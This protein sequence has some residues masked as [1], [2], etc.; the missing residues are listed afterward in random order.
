MCH[1]AN[2]LNQNVISLL[3]MCFDFC[4]VQNY[5]FCLLNY[6]NIIGNWFPSGSC[7]L[8]LKINVR[9]GSMVFLVTLWFYRV[10]GSYLRSRKVKVM[11]R[12]YY[13]CESIRGPTPPYSSKCILMFIESVHPPVFSCYRRRWKNPGRTFCFF[14]EGF[15][16]TI[17]ETIQRIN[18]C[19]RNVH[20]NYQVSKVSRPLVVRNLDGNWVYGLL[21][22][23]ICYCFWH[24][25]K[26]FV[27]PKQRNCWIYTN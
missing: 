8:F 9:F 16:G 20:S 21:T 13:T 6:P 4:F 14:R 26:I 19:I 17:V 7:S 12:Q 10:E 18:D 15:Q 11:N 22:E 3:R 24:M 2:C 25:N 23:R 1:Y 5:Q 27:N